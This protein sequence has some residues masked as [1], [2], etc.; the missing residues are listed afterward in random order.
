M[1]QICNYA[2]KWRICRENSKYVPDENFRGHF[3]PSWKAPNFC[4]PGGMGTSEGGCIGSVGREG[5]IGIG[6]GGREQSR[7]LSQNFPS[8]TKNCPKIVWKLSQSC[9]K[10][11]QSCL[12][13]I[14]NSS[15]I[16]SSYPKWSSFWL[17]CCLVMS[18]NVVCSSGHRDKKA[19][20]R[21][22]KGLAPFTYTVKL[23]KSCAYWP[24]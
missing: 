6:E 7:K 24:S 13:V 18:W 23:W 15:Q 14:Q 8:L 10:I 17:P 19:Y 22:S 1:V 3:C 12:K 4:H 2:K 9:L 21:V 5:G 20:G 16:S 11:P